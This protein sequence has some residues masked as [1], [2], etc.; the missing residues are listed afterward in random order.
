MRT[1]YS[2]GHS[3]R[4]AKALLALLSRAGIAVVADVRRVPASRRHPWFAR[5]AL[6]A[7]LAVAGIRYAWLGDGLGGRRSPER[8]VEASRNGA[9]RDAAFRAYAD[10]FDGDA[11]RRD[12]RALEELATAAPTAFLCAE[13]DW[14]RCHRR[15]LADVL[16]TRGWQVIHLVDEDRREPH[17]LHE[18]ARVDGTDVSYP[19]LL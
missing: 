9:L 6:D 17:R 13:R 2:V 15:L 8:P 3:N 18:W 4:E 14:R 12:L 7:D 19:A 11:F 16:T 5:A 1:V 10:A